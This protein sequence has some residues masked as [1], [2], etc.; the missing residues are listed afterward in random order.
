MAH[1][2]LRKKELEHEGQVVTLSGEGTYEN[3]M[4]RWMLDNGFKW[5][6]ED[7]EWFTKRDAAQVYIDIRKMGV[8]VHWDTLTDK[9]HVDNGVLITVISDSDPEKTYDIWQ[10]EDGLLCSCPGKKFHGYCKH[11]SRYEEGWYN[12]HPERTVS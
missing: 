7:Q 4:R 2:V 5:S 6:L 3:F 1:V 11:I 12:N 9:P 8:S 10:G